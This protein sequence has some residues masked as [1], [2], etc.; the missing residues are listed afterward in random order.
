MVVATEQS[1]E[2]LLTDDSLPIDD[3]LPIDEKSSGK[4]L[5]AEQFDNML[6]TCVRYH[7]AK[8]WLQKKTTGY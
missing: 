2:K 3:R 7:K 5:A 1:D 6:P 4:A 8:H